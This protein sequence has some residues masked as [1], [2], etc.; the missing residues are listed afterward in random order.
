MA[1]P[2][3]ASRP[4]IPD[5]RPMSPA[6]SSTPPRTCLLVA[7]TA[8]SSATSRRRWATSTLKVF[9]MTNDPTSSATPANT[10]ST[11]VKMPKASWTESTAASAACSPVTASTPS[12][13]SS[14]IRLRSS[15]ASTPSSARTSTS[16]TSPS[17]PSTCWAVGRSNPASVAPRMLSVSPKPTMPTS[18]KVCR[19][20]SKM[21]VTWSPTKNPALLAVCASTTSSW[22][23]EGTWPSRRW[24]APDISTVLVDV[25]AERGGPSWLDGLTVVVED[26]REARHRPLR[27]SHSRNATH[28]VHD[29]VVQG[30]QLTAGG[31]DVRVER[32][33]G[34]DHHVRS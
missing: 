25:R 13:S 24:P 27:G 22:G 26:E 6:S 12:G 10:S 29:A 8:R 14:A 11:V 1:S 4:T 15:L 20:S 7:P 34:P 21:T 30:A 9:Q 32:A 3:P 23:P 28:C 16:S 17:L 33:L 18:V 31:G 5:T 2:T 19:P